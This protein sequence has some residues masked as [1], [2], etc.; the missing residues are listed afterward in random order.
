MVIMSKYMQIDIRVLPVYEKRLWEQFPHITDL[1]RQM[2]YAEPVEKE[3]SLYVLVDYMVSLIHNPDAPE[4]V[5]NKIEKPVQEILVL[6]RLAREQLVSRR[7]N[8]LDQTLYLIED[9]FQDLEEA[10]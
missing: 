9:L 1:L 8:E 10:L 3:V 4:V 2:S 5:R 6:K 7:L